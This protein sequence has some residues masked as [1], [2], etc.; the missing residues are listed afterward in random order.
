LRTSAIDRDKQFGR[1]ETPEEGMDFKEQFPW[2][3]T[4]HGC[5]MN[6]DEKQSEGGRGRQ[7]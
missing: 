2:G 7:E 5:R 6:E 3:R 4:D 1:C